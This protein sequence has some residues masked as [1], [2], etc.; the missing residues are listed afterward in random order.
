MG[1]TDSFARRR[2]AEAD[3]LVLEEAGLLVESPVEQTSEPWLNPAAQSDNA[4]D[5]IKSYR[6]SYCNVTNI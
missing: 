1:T 3:L 5:S 2:Q 4:A 6:E